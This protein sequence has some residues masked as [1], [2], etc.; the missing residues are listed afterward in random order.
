MILS[1]L[2]RKAKLPAEMEVSTSTPQGS[3]ENFEVEVEE[4]MKRMIAGRE[5][6][7]DKAMSNIK[8]A[9]TR[10]KKDY[11]KKRSQSEVIILQ[12]SNFTKNSNECCPL[13]T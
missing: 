7:F 6:M 10:Y 12:S 9:Q 13:V 3:E 2:S 1:T 11:D 8:D 5:K 4:K